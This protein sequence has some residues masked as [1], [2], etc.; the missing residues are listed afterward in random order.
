MHPKVSSELTTG[1][2][3]SSDPSS[4]IKLTIPFRVDVSH[5]V[6][7]TAK[8]LPNRRP[9]KV[10]QFSPANEA[11]KEHEEEETDSNSNSISVAYQ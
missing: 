8:S 7:V 6:L 10:R 11:L 4:S 9:E 5:S 3:R 1:R 2:Q